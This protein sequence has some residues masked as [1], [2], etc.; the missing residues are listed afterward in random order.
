MHTNYYRL[1]PAGKYQW[2]E[3]SREES[4]RGAWKMSTRR[5]GVPVVMGFDPQMPPV[6]GLSPAHL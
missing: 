2:H 6:M 1:K 4:F 3:K 5:Q